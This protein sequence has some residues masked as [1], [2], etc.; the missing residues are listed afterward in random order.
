MQPLAFNTVV[1]N[2]HDVILLMTAMQCLFFAAL[3][4]ISNKQ[5]KL[6]TYF[7]AAFLL[8]HTLIPINEL[9]LWGAVFKLHMRANFSDFYLLPTIAYYLDGP[10]LFLLFKSLIFKD[11]SLRKLDVVHLIPLTC[12]VIFIC[13]AFYG[14]S[15]PEKMAALWSES[16]VYSP[17]FVW[18]DLANKWIRVGY[19]CACFALI[20]KY[21]F[22]LLD[23]H[24]SMEKSHIYWL[25]A[26]NAGFFLV[27]FSDA[28]L[29][30]FKALNTINYH[31]EGNL[32]EALGL[33]SNYFTFALVN[34]LIFSAIHQFWNFTQ[35]TNEAPEPPKKSERFINPEIAA[36]IDRA[37]REKKIYM[38][39]ELTLEKLSESLDIFPRDLSMLINRHFEVNFYEFINGYRIEEAKRMLTAPEHKKTTI[40]DIYLTVGFNSKSVF[41]NFFNK[42]EG[43]TPS[44]YRKSQR[45]AA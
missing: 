42:I 45:I 27:M 18:L 34:L 24:S 35:V 40:T 11:F 30:V 17:Q 3:L 38:E 21:Q 15:H 13:F 43:T 19:A 4:S 7:L 26:L 12:Y 29:V 2:F 16:F 33:T 41:Y 23:T 5:K 22:R 1:F 9:I 37:I 14:L 25:V 8:A 36:G 31:F 39:P 10:L 6:S 28:T 32:F 20:Y 44:Q